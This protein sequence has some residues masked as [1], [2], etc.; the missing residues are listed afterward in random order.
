MAHKTFSALAGILFLTLALATTVTAQELVTP[1]TVVGV[2]VDDDCCGAQ[3]LID[4]GGL[5]GEGLA[6]THDAVTDLDY[7]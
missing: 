1:T 5:D 2:A 6:A 4:G 7:L 3:Y